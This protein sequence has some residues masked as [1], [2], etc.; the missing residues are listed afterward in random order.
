[1]PDSTSV[2]WVPVYHDMGLMM[3]VMQPI[4]VG[5]LWVI[6]PPAAFMQRPLNWLRAIA[7]FRAE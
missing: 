7:R 4:Y 3:G 6:M 2:G 5:A 1:M